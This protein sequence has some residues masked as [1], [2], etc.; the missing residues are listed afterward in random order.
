MRMNYCV[1]RAAKGHPKQLT[2]SAG[3]S[4][5]RVEKSVGANGRRAGPPQARPALSG[6]SA[7]HAGTSVGDE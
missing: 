4:V 1:N 5:E 7:A 3:G 2:A 6:G